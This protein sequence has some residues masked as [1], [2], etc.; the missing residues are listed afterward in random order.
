MILHP[1]NP[2]ICIILFKTMGD[3]FMNNIITEYIKSML[4]YYPNPV[5]PLIRLILFKTM[6][7]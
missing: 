5:N 3:W 1:A 2:L 4:R 6:A 7:L